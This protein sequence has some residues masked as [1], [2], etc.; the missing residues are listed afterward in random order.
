MEF[1]QSKAEHIDKDSKQKFVITFIRGIR[2]E[3]N[4]MIYQNQY[5]KYTS[6][7]LTP[8]VIAVHTR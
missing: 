4:N 5:F 7:F 2:E 1:C 8:S 6:E 3:I